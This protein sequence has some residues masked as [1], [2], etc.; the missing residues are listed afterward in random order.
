[1]RVL[2]V[3]LRRQAPMGWIPTLECLLLGAHGRQR[4][5]ATTARC[6]SLDGACPVLKDLGSSTGWEDEAEWA[7]RW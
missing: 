5:T 6:L 2:V 7:N 1:M 3:E 4:L